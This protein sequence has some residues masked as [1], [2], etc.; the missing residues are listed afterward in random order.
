VKPSAASDG[1][2]IF[3]VLTL[4]SILGAAV[5]FGPG[6]ICG[7]IDGSTFAPGALHTAD[8]AKVTI[9]GPPSLRDR[10]EG[11]APLNRS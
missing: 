8:N 4:A 7:K 1:V 2:W 10:R 5:V 9:L 11:V 6:G 3:Y